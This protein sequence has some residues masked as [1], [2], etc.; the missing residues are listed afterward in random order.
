MAPERLAVARPAASERRFFGRRAPLLGDMVDRHGFFVDRENFERHAKWSMCPFFAPD[1]D[2]PRLFAHR[3]AMEARLRAGAA[4]KPGAERPSLAKAA[5]THGSGRLPAP[6]RTLAPAGSSSALADRGSRLV[7]CARS[8]A[9][10]AH[11]LPRPP[12]A[13][14][15][16]ARAAPCHRRFFASEPRSSWGS[17]RA[18]PIRETQ[19]LTVRSRIALSR[20]KTGLS[21]SLFCG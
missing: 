6:R 3:E 9:R 2:K 14:P 5:R 16:D 8:C 7:R 12:R 19:V 15:D 13:R 1:G 10:D 11:S 18:H 20:T 17:A 4:D 21:C